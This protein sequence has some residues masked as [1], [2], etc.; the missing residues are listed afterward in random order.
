V[1]DD[2]CYLR[3]TRG[4]GHGRHC[5]GP[6]RG[7]R[8]PGRRNVLVGQ[9]RQ[10]VDGRGWPGRGLPHPRLG[11]SRVRPPRRAA[12]AALAVVGADTPPPPLACSLQTDFSQAHSFIRSPASHPP[13]RSRSASG[14]AAGAGRPI[15]GVVAR[16]GAAQPDCP[17]GRAGLRLSLILRV[18]RPRCELDP[19]PGWAG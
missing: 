19:G 4:D 16:A 12:V 13:S 8:G 10:G 2:Q 6:R 14:P 1:T 5:D 11:F 9:G 7:S 17:A 15:T 18:R 3:G